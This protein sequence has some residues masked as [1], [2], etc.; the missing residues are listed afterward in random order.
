[1]SRYFD[2]SQNCVLYADVM[3]PQD[4]F[5]TTETQEMKLV[6]LVFEF[7]KSVAALKL[8]ETELALYSAAVLLSAGKYACAGCKLQ[9]LLLVF[10]LKG[11]F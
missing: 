5:F 4:A 8:T 1:M 2:L 9:D 10:Y 11:Y 6:T 3:L 7:A